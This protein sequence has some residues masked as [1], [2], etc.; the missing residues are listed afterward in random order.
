[1]EKINAGEMKASR[2]EEGMRESWFG[3]CYLTRRGLVWFLGRVVR[4]DLRA[5]NA[6]GHFVMVLLIL[7]GVVEVGRV[8]R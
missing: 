5:S 1:M 8:V 3:T 7:I 6:G 2:D 4:S